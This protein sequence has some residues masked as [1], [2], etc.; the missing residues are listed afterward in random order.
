LIT[1]P[2]SKWTTAST[3][4]LYDYIAM[5]IL[6][7]LIVKR[8]AHAS[9]LWNDQSSIDLSTVIFNWEHLSLMTVS[10]TWLLHSYFLDVSCFLIV[11]DAIVYLN[12]FFWTDNWYNVIWLGYFYQNIVCERDES[13]IDIYIDRDYHI[14]HKSIKNKA[15]H[16]QYQH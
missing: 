2:C 10:C 13:F 16:V 9:L 12:F 3:R 11:M 15:W 7:I 5:N 1:F 8:W 4:I 6:M 14:S